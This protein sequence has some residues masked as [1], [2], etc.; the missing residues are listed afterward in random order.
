MFIYLF[1]HPDKSHFIVMGTKTLKD[2]KTRQILKT[3]NVYSVETF[4]VLKDMMKHLLGDSE[5]KNKILLREIKA[6][7]EF[8]GQ[9]DIGR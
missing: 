3:E 4:V 6:M 7:G 8:T 9:T 2:F 1:E 5:V